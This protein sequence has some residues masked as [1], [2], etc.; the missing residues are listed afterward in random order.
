MNFFN[1]CN[2]KSDFLKKDVHSVSDLQESDNSSSL[3]KKQLL[4]LVIMMLPQS[5][6][7]NSNTALLRTQKTPAFKPGGLQ[8][9][10][11]STTKIERLEST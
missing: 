10:A 2:K 8:R 1:C 11:M 5:L 3:P 7:F 6:G 9:E 4:S